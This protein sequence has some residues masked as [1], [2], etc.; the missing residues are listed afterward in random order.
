MENQ[1]KPVRNECSCVTHIHN[2]EACAGGTGAISFVHRQW[3]SNV[4]LTGIDVEISFLEIM[5]SVQVYML[6]EFKK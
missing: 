1:K 4:V 6:D 5:G 3:P 2:S